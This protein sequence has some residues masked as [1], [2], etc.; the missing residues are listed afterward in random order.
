MGTLPQL[1][2]RVIIGLESATRLTSGLRPLA[3]IM[4]FSNVVQGVLSR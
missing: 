3:A 1:L 2:L 4:P